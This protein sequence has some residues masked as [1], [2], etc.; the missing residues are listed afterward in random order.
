MPSASILRL[1]HLVSYWVARL[2]SSGLNVELGSFTPK[3]AC[4]KL[5]LRERIPC[6]LFTKAYI[7]QH[8]L[9]DC[10][11]DVPNLAVGETDLAR[12]LHLVRQSNP[13]IYSNGSQHT[14]AG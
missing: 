4:R 6:S 5:M 8:T 7:T 2:L 14:T 3:K 11:G 9:Q 13:G 10:I 1:D 12:R